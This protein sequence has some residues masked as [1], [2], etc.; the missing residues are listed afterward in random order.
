MRKHYDEALAGLMEQYSRFH[1]S[2]ENTPDHMA[3][4]TLSFQRL[5]HA[6]IGLSTE[7]AELLDVCKKHMYGKQVTL[8]DTHVENM[9]EECGD[10]FF[11]L[12]LAMTALE[13]SFEDMLRDNIAKLS[14]RYNK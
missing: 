12:W 7:S 4:H 9:R 13:Y 5:L 14:K 11:Y 6:S 10:V 2:V 3:D 1:T 8:N